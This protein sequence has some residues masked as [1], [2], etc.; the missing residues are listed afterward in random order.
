MYKALTLVSTA[1]VISACSSLGKADSVSTTKEAKMDDSLKTIVLSEETLQHHHWQL[2][3]IDGAAVESIENFKAPTL[4]IGENMST[5]GHAGCN[6]FFGQGE[7]NEGK[8][9]IQQMAT[10]MKICPEAVMNIEMAYS[11]AL[12]EW[13]VVTLTQ[14]GLELENAQHTL[15]FE[16]KDWVN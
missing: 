13:S 15:V 2:T 12:V 10:T 7:L 11:K 16:L 4:E 5:N 8:F 6:N 14:Q 1:L 3:M 9:R